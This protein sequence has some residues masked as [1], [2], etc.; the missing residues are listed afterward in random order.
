MSLHPP[1]NSKTTNNRA[2]FITAQD[3]PQTK[4]NKTQ[5]LFVFLRWLGTLAVFALFSTTVLPK[6]PNMKW[7]PI[8][9]NQLD[10]AITKTLTKLQLKYGADKFLYDYSVLW[11]IRL[12]RG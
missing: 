2:I 11:E 5:L 12:L 9:P 4:L 1:T 8:N 7:E 10:E 6:L 3:Y